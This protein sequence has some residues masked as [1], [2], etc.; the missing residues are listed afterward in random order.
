MIR[1]LDQLGFGDLFCRYVDHDFATYL[2]VDR[3]FLIVVELIG[4]SWSIQQTVLLDVLRRIPTDSTVGRVL[5][6]VKER[7]VR[8]LESLVHALGSG[9]GPGELADR[10]WAC[11]LNFGSTSTPR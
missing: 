10:K 6:E 3:V 7:H 5:K 8:G 9:N 11:S 2:L 4:G 1:F